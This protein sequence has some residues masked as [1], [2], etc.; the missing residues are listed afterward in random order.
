MKRIMAIGATMVMLLAGNLARSEDCGIVNP[1]FEEGETEDF[2]IYLATDAP[3]GWSV[4]LLGGNF[5]GYVYTDWDREVPD[6]FYSLTMHLVKRKQYYAGDTATV[7][8]A[9]PIDLSAVTR[10]T[11]AVKL[12]TASGAWDPNVCSAVALID[13]N[14]VWE[15]NSVGS[16]VRGEYAASFAVD[17]E[18]R[19][20]EHILSLGMRM[21]IDA[22]YY[23]DKLY[24]THWDMVDCNLCG[25]VG[26]VEGDI[27]GDCCVDAND[28]RLLAEKWLSDDVD[29]NDP[30]NLSDVGDDPN[31]YATIDFRDFAVHASD[32]DGSM[33]ILEALAAYW[34][35]VVDPDY[36]YNLFGEDDIRPR[37][38]I[39]FFDLAVLGRNWLTCGGEQ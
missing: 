36:E 6:D 5:D 8:Q 24:K 4:D 30:A 34:L 23:I 33:M 16:D 37:G 21:N 31:G 25:G 29:P 17:R 11:F 20:P 12:D 27:D 22:F 19:S 7:S 3:I 28:L 32:W 1:S 26:S 14:V 15:S 35:D 13:G 9:Q 2:P 18:Y 10:I 39:N 38:E